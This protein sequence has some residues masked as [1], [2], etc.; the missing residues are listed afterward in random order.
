MK[1]ET[2]AIVL[3]AAWFLSEMLL[4]RTAHDRSGADVDRR[5]MLIL[6]SSNLFIPCVCMALYLFGIGANAFA[7]AIKMIGIAVMLFGFGIRWAGMW[8]LRKFFS[9][10]V[11]VQA[12]HRLIVQGPYRF[13]RHP[14]YF[15]G[16]LSFVGLGLALGDWLALL[17][18]AFLTAP[19]FLFRIR[20]EE[21][22]L[23]HAFPDYSAYAVKVKRFVPF[24]W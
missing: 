9:A 13:V 4:L 5:S 15:G 18:L 12:D 19:A 6:A 7:P 10:N 3:F 16:W 22:M 17:I 24:V 23:R 20:V 14:G 21:S 1:I 11:A 2:L 8:T